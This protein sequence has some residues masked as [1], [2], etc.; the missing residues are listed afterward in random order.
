M[1]RV[2][3]FLPQ[4]LLR[5][6]GQPEPKPEPRRA[7][8]TPARVHLK[9]PASSSKITR[10]AA[11]RAQL[12]RDRANRTRGL[13]GRLLQWWT[14]IG[15]VL[16]GLIAVPALVISTKA[17]SVS[18]QQHDDT[19]QLFAQRVV[20]GD[21]PARKQ[22]FLQHRT[23]TISN[24]NSITVRTTFTVMHFDDVWKSQLYMAAIPSCT[25]ID[26]ALSLG[27][28]PPA[29]ANV[30]IFGSFYNPLDK[31]QWSVTTMGGPAKPIDAATWSE[32]TIGVPEAEIQAHTLRPIDECV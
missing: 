12:R 31:Q 11:K 27:V 15:T 32:M 17:L 8:R 26:Y 16:A 2:R 1:S 23:V 9:H 25:E 29:D 10:L 14:T 28:I 6:L 7:I 22:Q 19:R 24:G 20:M 5:L 3:R 4:L 30:A 21:Y 18:K 13:E